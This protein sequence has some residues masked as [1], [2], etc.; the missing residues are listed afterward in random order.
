MTVY[1]KVVILKDKPC[2]W[3]ETLSL[4]C[5]FSSPIDMCAIY[6]L[7]F[8]PFRLFPFTLIIS[9]S[10]FIPENQIAPLI[11]ILLIH[12]THPLR[13]QICFCIITVIRFIICLQTN[14]PRTINQPFRFKVTDK[15][16]ICHRVIPITEISIDQ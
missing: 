1:D 13:G 12:N 11:N 16:R 8:S 6:R 3:L 14:I 4:H 9:Y 15:I 2:L 7:L 10:P 5:R